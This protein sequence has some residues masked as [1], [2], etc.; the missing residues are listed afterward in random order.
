MITPEE[1]DS[2]EISGTK[3]AIPRPVFLTVLC[4]ISL[5]YFALLSLFFIAGL[6]NATWITG[7]MNQYLPA[8]DYTKTQTLLFFGTGLFLHGLA[9]TGVL[10]IWNLRKTGYYFLGIS[11]LITAIYQ[12]INPLAAITST[13]IYIAF[14]LLFGFFFRRLH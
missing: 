11:C 14:I 8:V 9:V 12:L 6:S 13:A 5:V 1:T 3:Q 4:L 2:K 7:V 10:L